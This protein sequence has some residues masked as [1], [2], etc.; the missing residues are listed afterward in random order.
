[1]TGWTALSYG[2]GAV[3]GIVT[4]LSFNHEWAGRLERYLQASGGSVRQPD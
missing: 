3:N 2:R 1:M 4:K